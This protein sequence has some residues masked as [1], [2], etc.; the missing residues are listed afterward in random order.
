MHPISDFFGAPSS[1]AF[2]RLGLITLAGLSLSAALPAQE[3]PTSASASGAKD[4]EVVELS[5]F[6]VES[7][8]ADSYTALNT[9]SVTRF[10]AEL[11]RLPVSADVYT[12]K[13]IEDTASTSIEEMVVEYGTGT[14]IGGNNPEGAAEANRPGDR[15]SNVNVKIRGLDAGQMRVNSFGAGGIDDTFTVE[16]VDVVRGPQ[17]LLNGGV[18][19]GGV[20]NAVTKRARFNSKLS[21]V[22]VRVDEHG[23]L[24]GIVDYGVGNDRYAVRLSAL[25]EDQ[26]YSRII[27]GSK[28]VGFYGQAAIQLTRNTTLRGEA[29]TKQSETINSTTGLTLSAPA[30]TINGVRLP[31]DPRNGRRIRALY[32]LGEADDILDGGITWENVDSFRGPYYGQD[33]ENTRYEGSIEHKFGTWGVLE[34]AAMHD[35]SS[36]DRA[37]TNSFTN[38]AAPRR[39]NNP[40][41]AWAVG[42]Q[43]GNTHESFRRRGYRANLAAEFE[44]LDGRARTQ[45]VMGAQYETVY[46]RRR[47]QLYYLADA[48]GNIVVNQ[49]QIGN[50][51]VGR[52]PMPTQWFALDGGPMNYLPFPRGAKSITA[53]NGNN[54]VLDERVFVGAVDPTPTNPLG[55]RGTGSFWDQYNY[56]DSYFGAFAT[57]WFDDRFTTLVGYRKSNVENK[58]YE[59]GDFK[60][61]IGSFDSINFGLNFKLTDTLRPYY[62][63]SNAY[64]PPDIVQFGPDGE[65]TRTSKST[66]HELGI[67]FNPRS[68]L[69]SGSF[70]VYTVESEDEQV[71][72]PT[73]LR[74]DINPAGINGANTPSQNWIN[75]MRE[76]K[77]AELIVTA[78]LRDN[79]DARLTVAYTDGTVGESKRYAIFYNDEFNTDGQG[80]VTYADGTPLLVAVDP[81]QQANPNA[82]R[83]QLTIAMMNDPASSYFAVLDP[84]SGRITNAAALQLNT[85][86]PSGA[87]VGT[88]RTGLPISAH[89]LLFNDP[90]GN[91]GFITVA[92][93]GEPTSGY[94]QYSVNLSNQ[95]TIKDGALR[96]LSLG[97]TLMYRASDRTYAYT[98]V[99]RNEAGIVV[100]SERRMFSLD[101]SLRFN[102]V[103]SYKRRLWDRIDWTTQ[104]NISN[105]FDDYDVVVMPNVNTGDPQTARYT[106]EPRT[107]V[108][109]NTFSF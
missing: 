49:A 2:S 99:F 41:D 75:L 38:L 68:G 9:N 106:T 53:S 79:W 12:S 95:Y 27:L 25:A 61:S 69:F 87:S 1:R 50:N 48:E 6:M 97:G 86:S 26:S 85:F 36:M 93:A 29:S 37:E 77:G 91:G 64:N 33:R 72:I 13:F 94:A 23:S 11:S 71:S 8:G 104:V 103:I 4:E 62:G 82:P 73:D 65:V 43:P 102:A 59:V 74:T 56:I 46:N 57:D 42:W 15:A 83:Q 98:Q 35:L 76:S 96:G 45:A 44:L 30:V 84:D 80:G 107:F 81:S 70:S 21:R 24:R 39:N 60:R 52:T 16:R 22:Q 101:D 109:T 66:G 18:G 32:A 5:P 55:V 19:G 89:Q 7:A 90:N 3:A 28:G 10:R 20:V 88:G 51:N 105:L 67:K 14:G 78:K 100:D 40:Y 31:A 92:Q 58:R 47:S 63:F 17:S 54:Y 108:W 34:L